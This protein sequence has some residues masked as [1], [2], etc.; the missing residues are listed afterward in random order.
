MLAYFPSLISIE[1]E[2]D[3]FCVPVLIISHLSNAHTRTSKAT[4]TPDALLQLLHLHNLRR[5]NPLQNQLCNT[6]VLLNHKVDI[7]V[8]EQQNLDLSSVIRINDAGS[9]VDEVLGCEAGAWG[10]ASVCKVGS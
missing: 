8:I 7:A 10:D 2:Q 9:R 3:K 1:Q 6:I 4:L 5:V